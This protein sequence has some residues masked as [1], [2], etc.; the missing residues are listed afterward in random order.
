MSVLGCCKS[1]AF[2][3]KAVGCGC[4]L[5]GVVIV[6]EKTAFAC[7]CLV[8]VDARDPHD[9]TEDGDN[10]IVDVCTRAQRTSVQVMEE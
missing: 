7:D 6:V 3:D 4:C 8:D 2:A 1:N 5:V 10:N 9:E